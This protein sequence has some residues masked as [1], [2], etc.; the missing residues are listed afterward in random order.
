MTELGVI[1]RLCLSLKSGRDPDGGLFY[2]FISSFLIFNYC[3]YFEIRPELPG[4]TYKLSPIL[5]NGY[6]CKGP[7]VSDF[8]VIHSIRGDLKYNLATSQP[9]IMYVF[10]VVSPSVS[11]HVD[12][13]E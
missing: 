8:A 10:I 1:K 2:L 6:Y 3:K 4:V 11:G 12:R 5:K 13:K 9:A 7:I